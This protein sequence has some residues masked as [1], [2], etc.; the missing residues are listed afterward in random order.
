MGDPVTMALVGAG[1]G[2]GTSLLRGKGLGSALQNAAIG[3]ALGGIGG[4]AGNAI[5]GASAVA[6]TTAGAF[7]ASMNLPL[8]AG[9]EAGLTGMTGANTVGSMGLVNGLNPEYYTNILGTPT[10]KGGEG[11]LAN[12]TGGL[13]NKLPDYVTPQNV[14]GAARL[15]SEQQPTPM[16]PSSGRVSQGNTQGLNVNMG[17][18]A[19][20]ALRKREDW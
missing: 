5:K 7:E 8:S 12:Y 6:P 18:A 1:I 20:I 17:M 16:Q 9:Y 13:L 10:Y 19:P 15:I 14:I 3:G 11:L 4:A 2:G